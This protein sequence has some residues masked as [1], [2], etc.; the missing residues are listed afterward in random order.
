MTG[1]LVVD[2]PF[3]PVCD[4]GGLVVKVGKNAI[5]A[6]GVPFKEGDRVAGCTRLG[7]KGYSPSGEF[8]CLRAQTEFAVARLT[9]SV[10]DGC[11]A[12]HSCAKEHF[13]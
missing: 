8:V 10:P 2:W 1:L 12:C 11:E 13:L 3:T 5:N 9:C 7:S 6:L 4:A